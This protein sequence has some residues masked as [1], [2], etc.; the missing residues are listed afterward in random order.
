MT[1]SQPR[2][3]V[4]PS[5]VEMDAVVGACSGWNR[6][7]AV[8]LRYTGCRV[9]ET[10]LLTWS[11]LDL[12][13]GRLT[14]RPEID[15]MGRGRVIPLSPYLLAELEGWGVREGYIVPTNGDGDR[16]RQ[17]RAKYMNHRWKKTGVR[18][19]AW[20]GDP[21]H[22]FRKGFKSGLLA[23]GCQPDAVDYLQGHELGSGARGRYID[24]WQAL[25]LE[26]VVGKI[27]LIGD[28]NLVPLAAVR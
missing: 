11:D 13:T 24:P 3:V 20:T 19:E 6:S 9:G 22:A 28:S 27:P 2:P 15:K 1:R 14:I 25:H 21:H 18:A 17:A 16:D 5:W 10:M 8:I 26:D 7:L 12:T 4:A 23:L